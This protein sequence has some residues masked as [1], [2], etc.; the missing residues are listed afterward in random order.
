MGI[1]LTLRIPPQI[2]VVAFTV[3]LWLPAD[4]INWTDSKLK[5]V[6]IDPSLK[7]TGIQLYVFELNSRLDPLL[8]TN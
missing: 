8:T 4:T 2:H 7:I 3:V 5:H 6:N 1:I